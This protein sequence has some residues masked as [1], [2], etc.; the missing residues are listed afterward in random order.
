M[1]FEYPW[2]SL[3]LYFSLFLFPRPPSRE[4]AL[5]PVTIYHLRICNSL[6]EEGTI[7]TVAAR[8]FHDYTVLKL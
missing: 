2:V 8:T 6:S 3:L 5:T 4:F 1:R 7:G